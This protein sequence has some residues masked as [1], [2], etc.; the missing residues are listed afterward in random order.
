MELINISHLS[1][2]YAE[3]KVLDNLSVIYESGVIYGLVGENGAGKTTLFNSI[4]G[5][6]DYEGS[7]QKAPGISIGYLPAE[8]HFYTLITG[9]EYLDFCI[10]AKGQNIEKAKIEEANE[11]FQ[12]PLQRYASEYSTGMKKKLAL[13][14]LLL[15]DNDL[16]ILDEPFNGVDLYGFIRLKR[17]I[18]ELKDKG[19]TIIISSHLLNTLHELCDEIDFLDGH[20]IRKRYIHASI[21]EIEKDIL[22]TAKFTTVRENANFD[23]L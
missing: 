14:S 6:A 3:M 5:I 2:S 8:N 16:Y 1:K 11:I 20:V 4:M 13:M 18:R 10:R 23:S 22:D 17:I 21:N 15:Q 7:I 12:L 9:Q 19:K